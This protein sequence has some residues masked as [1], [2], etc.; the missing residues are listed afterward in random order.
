M[1]S[2]RPFRVLGVQQVAIGSINRQPL[3]TLWVELLGLEPVRIYRSERENVDEL[4]TRI[5]N[6]PASVEV[7]LMQPIDPMGHPRIHEP[8]LHH[9]G[10][11]VDNLR[12]AVEWLSA[13]GVRFAQGGIRKGASGHEVCFIHPKGNQEF[14]IGGCG[15][16]IELVQA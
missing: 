14:P 7:D 5:G 2:P 6:G 10:L 8:P 12:A 16:L 4:I 9:I 3:V 13:R 15:V 11:W 1:S